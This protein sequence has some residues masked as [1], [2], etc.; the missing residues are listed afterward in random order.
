MSNYRL[1]IF[2][3]RS[4]TQIAETALKYLARNIRGLYGS[5]TIYSLSLILAAVVICLYIG[6]PFNATENIYLYRNLSGQHILVP[7]MGAFIL[8]LVGITFHN[9]IISRHLIQSNSVEELEG[10]NPKTLLTYLKEDF[11]TLFFNYLLLTG[12]LYLFNF[13]YEYVMGNAYDS[14]GAYADSV[15]SLLSAFIST[16]AGWLPYIFVFPLLHYFYIAILFVTLKDGAGL[17]VA[18]N[19][20]WHYSGDKLKN[21]WIASAV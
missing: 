10:I 16:K 14:S 6:L 13:G 5:I 17:G 11:M 20:V 9:Q 19:K 1:D 2:K 18:F 21:V 3:L 15:G 4:N 8:R 12:F 7:L